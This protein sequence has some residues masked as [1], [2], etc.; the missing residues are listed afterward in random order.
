MRENIN[1]FFDSEA[2]AI[3]GVSQN[4]HKFGYTVFKEFKDKNLNVYPVNK[5]YDYLVNE[6]CF[7]SVEQLPDE[8][9]SIVT[10]V[11]PYEAILVVRQA[12]T[13]EIKNIWMQ[14][15]SFSKEALSAASNANIS[16]VHNQCILMFLE[17]VKSFHAFHRWI[18]KLFGKYPK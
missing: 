12:I 5:N 1:R 10:V 6:K 16:I 9:Q 18:T 17:P 2:F 11:P 14:P 8:V 3:V 4:K 15:G 13:K 7:Q